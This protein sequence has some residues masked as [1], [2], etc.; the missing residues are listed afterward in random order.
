M[1]AE[2]DIV[3]STEEECLEWKK[4]PGHRIHS[5]CTTCPREGIG[6]VNFP[7]WV[8]GAHVNAG[9]QSSTPFPHLLCLAEREKHWGRS[10][11]SLPWKQGLNQT[12]VRND[13]KFSV[14]FLVFDNI[15]SDLLVRCFRKFNDQLWEGTLASPSIFPARRSCQ[16]ITGMCSS[17]DVTWGFGR[18]SFPRSFFPCLNSGQTGFTNP[19]LYS[20]KMS[21]FPSII[22]PNWKINWGRY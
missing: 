20:Q 12:A 11:P 14:T 7:T 1:K 3:Q 5:P 19:C 22:I 10:T 4:L 13:F 8:Y 6:Q 2:E 21:L 18:E 15:R 9:A 17:T 16:L